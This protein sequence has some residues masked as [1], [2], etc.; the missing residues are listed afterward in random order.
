MKNFDPESNFEFYKQV[1]DDKNEEV[2]KQME[3]NFKKVVIGTPNPQLVSHIKVNFYDTLTPINEVASI[4]S[5]SALQLLIKP[6]DVAL[7]KTIAS[8]IVASKIDAQVQK[9]ANQVR[10]IFPE[11]TLEK[12][13]ESIVQ[14]KKYYEE[15]KIRV[16]LVRQNLNKLIKKEGFPEDFE[17]H[18]L[19]VIQKSTDHE[20]EKLEILFE[21]KVKEIQS[22]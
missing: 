13:Q 16:R 3:K 6:Y 20:T 18:F 2:C 1:L 4:S 7:V 17:K 19:D 15:A 11:L 14:I 9:E 5:P 21:K 22:T 10:V 12:R 8:A